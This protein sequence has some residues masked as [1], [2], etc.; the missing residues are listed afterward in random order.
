MESSL[1]INSIIFEVTS[2]AIKAILASTIICI[3]SA[4][5]IYG[6]RW[7]QS[8]G[9]ISKMMDIV[10]GNIKFKGAIYI[11]IVILIV[12]L[13]SLLTN[14]L[15]N[16]VFAYTASVIS[17]E[18]TYLNPIGFSP[19]TPLNTFNTK[20]MSDSIALHIL[21]NYVNVTSSSRQ[22]DYE[23]YIIN[24]TDRGTQQQTVVFKYD[25]NQNI[26]YNSYLL[27]PII[28]TDD[29]ND[30]M[31]A[32]GS[33]YAFNVSYIDDQ[34]AYAQINTS[35]LWPSIPTFTTLQTLIASISLGTNID[36]GLLNL[37][38][39]IYTYG[40]LNLGYDLLAPSGGFFYELM[41]VG[42]DYN[43]AVTA[44][45]SMLT[46]Q[47]SMKTSASNY[48]GLILQHR[49]MSI[50]EDTSNNAV[51]AIMANVTDSKT[52][53]IQICEKFFNSDFNQY[54]ISTL[55]LTYG[56]ALSMGQPC[57]GSG[58]D[59][60]LGFIAQ[61]YP[62]G[63]TYSNK[64]LAV[65]SIIAG[66]PSITD[67][68]NEVVDSLASSVEPIISNN[69]WVIDKITIQNTT[70]HS[71]YIFANHIIPYNTVFI[72]K[73][74]IYLSVIMVII[75]ITL[76]FIQR[77]KNVAIYSLEPLT[78]IASTAPH[79]TKSCSS[80]NYKYHVTITRVSNGKHNCILI[81]DSLLK[82]IA[83][84]EMLLPS[85]LSEEIEGCETQS[86]STI[87]PLDQEQED[88]VVVNDNVIPR[89][90]KL[91]ANGDIRHTALSIDGH[92]LE[93]KSGD[94]FESIT[95]KTELD[96]LET[97]IN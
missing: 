27:I 2:I 54:V 15:L 83:L 1:V 42:A 77:R 68:I 21:S 16:D 87:M 47:D 82:T 92:I 46:W 33:T 90:W 9:I 84:D 85:K 70:I 28:G 65:G 91:V 11:K 5:K 3:A 61:D 52:I 30:T 10:H 24:D 48:N 50:L 96:K 4:L 45:Y 79:D 38:S 94:G 39:Q 59:I 31:F 7:W 69:K 22:S 89:N 49:C 78:V 71:Q 80:M 8:I 95:T 72:A 60:T 18:Y 41:N 36:G 62:D 17:Q 57:P 29:G 58:N 64:V 6:L 67:T 81:N 76:Q 25:P 51:S 56:S 37:M 23:T 75:A 93:L 20:V 34:Y 74:G 73:S 63:C 32:F 86:R 53:S 43:Y 26:D 66:T 97:Y 88:Q 13:L 40:P 35:Y 12:L 44:N 55:N 14:I 19:I